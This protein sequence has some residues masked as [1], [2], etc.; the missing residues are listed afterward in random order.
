M[1]LRYRDEGRGC[2]VIFVHGWTLDLDQWEPQATSL[3]GEFRVVRMDR[4]GFGLSSGRPSTGED[5]ADL[6]AL[7]RH[8]GLEC[9]ALVGMSQGARAVVQFAYAH[10]R[11]TSCFILDGSPRFGSEDV[12]GNS[13]DVPH[14]VIAGWPKP[15]VSMRFGANGGSMRSYASELRTLKHTRCFRG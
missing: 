7:C 1:R 13:L 8:L 5:A 6:H 2:A 12:A 9:A 4:R 3:A 14:N 15:R 10:P 11:M